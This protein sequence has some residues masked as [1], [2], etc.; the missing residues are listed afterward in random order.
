MIRSLTVLVL[1][2]TI[3]FSCKNDEK[4]LVEQ[5]VRFSISASAAPTGGR[6]TTTNELQSVIVTIT[7]AQGNV[8][9]DR[10]KLQL[11]KFGE[12][13]LSVP[14][15][16]KTSGSSD[17]QLNEFFVTDA[18]EAVRYVTPMEGSPKA[19]LVNDPL[20]IGFT[21]TKDAVATISPEVIDVNENSNPADFGYA[22]FG[23]SVVKT[24]Q[25][26]FS[27]F[28]KAANSFELTTSH[29]KVEGLSSTETD[30][31]VLWSYETDLEAKANTLTLKEAP[32]YR[33]TVAKP[34]YAPWERTM[35]LVNNQTITIE[36]ISTSQQEVDIYIGG[37]AL[38][39]NKE[40]ATYWKNEVPIHIDTDHGSAI[41]SMAVAGEDIYAIGVQDYLYQ[42]FYWKNGEQIMLDHPAKGRAT[43]LFVYGNDV[44]ISGY[45]YETTTVYPHINYHHPV[46]WKNGELIHLPLPTPGWNWGK[47]TGIFVDGGDVYISGDHRKHGYSNFIL[48]P[49]IWKNGIMTELP[50][51]SA[52]GSGTAWNIRVKD[53]HTYSMESDGDSHYGYW[54]D[55][56]LIDLPGV[57]P[58]ID[59]LSIATSYFAINN[60]DFYCLSNYV[61]SYYKGTERI[62]IS[63]ELFRKPELYSIALANGNIYIVGQYFIKTSPTTGISPAAYWVNGVL[64][65]LPIQTSMAW[66]I[67]IV[68]R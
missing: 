17:Y 65:E 49:V 63:P 61:G 20:A 52:D 22:Q 46:Y 14:I 12:T 57:N 19:H 40:V 58:R 2:C 36:L 8:V 39:N 11:H 13:Y 10:K 54:K 34:G 7:D 66:T 23:F 50:T 38:Y 24:V 16:L 42:A 5:T 31:T 33:F 45:Y 35:A 15:T 3:F 37:S 43:G 53:G 41:L 27:S 68:P 25:A 55:S 51:R 60:D 44:Y 18:N 1:L 6:T 28:I 29:L 26:V 56:Q 64:H 9:T 30:A 21:I 32:N 62:F 67:Q 4:V 59:G 47:T 48:K